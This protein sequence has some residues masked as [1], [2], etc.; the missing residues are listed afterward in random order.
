MILGIGTTKKKNSF[1]LYT[2]SFRGQLLN[3]SKSRITGLMRKAFLIQ[4]TKTNRKKEFGA[5]RAKKKKKAL[6]N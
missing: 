2:V 1:K 3:M 4:E 6:E 5:I